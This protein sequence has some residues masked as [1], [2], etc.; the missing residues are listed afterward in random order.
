[1][2]NVFTPARCLKLL[3]QSMLSI[4]IC[5][6][7]VSPAVAE[8]AIYDPFENFNRHLFKL[9]DRV[10]VDIAE[11]VAK[12]Y[13][14]ITTPGMRRSVGN[15]FDNLRYPQYLVSDLLQF[16]IGQAFE[17]T[18]RFLVCLLYTSPSPRDS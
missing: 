9:N 16:K 2:I 5:L 15:F 17:H 14:N 12:R 6:I 7:V 3:L 1:M 4:F 8:D 13:G 18:G 11:P 10:D